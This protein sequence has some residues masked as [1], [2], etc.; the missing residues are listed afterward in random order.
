MAEDYLDWVCD[1]KGYI[2]LTAFWG[3]KE[4]GRCVQLT[5]PSDGYSQMSFDE[6]R[7]FFR[8]A[9]RLTD[10]LEEGLNEYPSDWDKTQSSTGSAKK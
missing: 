5:T 10:A 9:I 3:G 2:K 1:K 6:A 4:Y 8:D 7:K